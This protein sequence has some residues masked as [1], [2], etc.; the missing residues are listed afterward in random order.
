M[1][2]RQGCAAEYF[3][4]PK[5]RIQAK[6]RRAKIPWI[7]NEKWKY[8]VGRLEKNDENENAMLHTAQAMGKRA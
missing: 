1:E 6:N 4:N 8:L 5:N 7:S 3:K 2:F